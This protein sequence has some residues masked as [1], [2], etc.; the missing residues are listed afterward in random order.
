[1]IIIGITG[2]IGTG[3]TTVSKMLKILKIP[4]F[5]SD[6][7][8]KEILDK[9]QLVIEKILKI[10][11]DAITSNLIQRK[12]DK[13][14]LSN[15]IFNNKKERKKLEGIIHPI[16]EKERRTFLKNFEN[17]YIVGLDVPL[18]YETG[19]D[20]ECDYVLLMYAS[21]KIQK[22]RVLKRP[23]MTEKKFVL[24]NKAQ[25]SFERKIKEKPFIINTSFGKIITFF[26]VLFYLLK[27]KFSIK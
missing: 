25:W 5:D 11:P 20:K 9:N 16:I 12:I 19:K 10:W 23:N 26:Q 2:S 14:V 18:L 24:I 13:V 6:E 27:I 7:K 4:I 8:V 21:K 3:K 22:E 17:F 1:M 15:K